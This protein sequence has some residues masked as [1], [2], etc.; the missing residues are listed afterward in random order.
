MY[1]P[2]ALWLYL[3]L[4]F[5]II[6]TGNSPLDHQLGSSIS[7][8][9]RLRLWVR[10]CQPRHGKNFSATSAFTDHL[11][12]PAIQHEQPP[13]PL[14]YCLL[15]PSVIFGFVA[16]PLANTVYPTWRGGEPLWLPLATSP[17]PVLGIAQAPN[18]DQTFFNHSCE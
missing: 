13:G 3:A 10:L 2:G 1:I 15:W 8:V 11:R 7:G 18:W 17:S 12:M 14:Q 5:L 16:N 4:P 9:G 6:L